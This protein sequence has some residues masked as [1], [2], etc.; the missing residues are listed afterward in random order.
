MKKPVIDLRYIEK[1]EINSEDKI[2]AV[3]R[4]IFDDIDRHISQ[5]KRLYNF[6]KAYEHARRFA[7]R[8]PSYQ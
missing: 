7:N 2:F 8:I 4:M 3:F 5:N 1:N 6:S